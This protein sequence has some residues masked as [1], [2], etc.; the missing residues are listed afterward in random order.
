MTDSYLVFQRIF[1]Q[2]KDKVDGIKDIV[3]V[4]D[5]REIQSLQKQN[6][7]YPCLVVEMPDVQRHTEKQTF[8]YLTNWSVV[9]NIGTNESFT[10]YQTLL[11]EMMTLTQKVHDCLFC[12]DGEDGWS[13][14]TDGKFYP[15][16]GATADNC[17]GWRSDAEI[18][19]F[20]NKILE[21]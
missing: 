21:A 17:Y 13:G 10:A 18:N 7:A 5:W 14:E 1:E 16:M 6:L 11:G 19:I 8:D 12:A 3:F 2:L 15:I 4:T 20:S 9:S